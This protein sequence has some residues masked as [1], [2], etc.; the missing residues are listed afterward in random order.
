MWNKKYLLGGIEGWEDNHTGSLIYPI[1]RHDWEVM[2]NG[3]LLKTLKTL[4]EA[5]EYI[6]NYVTE[7]CM[8][9]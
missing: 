2:L 4:E 6:D 9:E 1:H 7:R 8:N 5:N 3:S